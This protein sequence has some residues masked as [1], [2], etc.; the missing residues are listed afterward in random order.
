MRLHRTR[1]VAGPLSRLLLGVRMAATAAVSGRLPPGALVQSTIRFDPSLP[2]S[3]PAAFHLPH[4]PKL[5]TFAAKNSSSRGLSLQKF[6]FSVKHDSHNRLSPQRP[7]LTDLSF[8]RSF[9][10][11]FSFCSSSILPFFA[12]LLFFVSFLHFALPGLVSGHPCHLLA[13]HDQLPPSFA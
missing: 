2:I 13:L 12:F 8:L 10:S 9:L 4:F 3:T 7:L 6:T 5:H 11:Y 1:L